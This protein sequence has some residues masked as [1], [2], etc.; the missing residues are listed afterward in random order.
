MVQ[1][2][3]P[4]D[5]IAGIQRNWD[6]PLNKIPRLNRGMILPVFDRLGHL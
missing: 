5:L 3:S 6:F 1:L 2:P 4:R